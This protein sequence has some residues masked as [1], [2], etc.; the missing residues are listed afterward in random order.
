MKFIDI[1]LCALLGLAGYTIGEAI[2]SQTPSPS[3]STLMTVPVPGFVYR[4]EDSSIETLGFSTTTDDLGSG[5]SRGRATSFSRGMP[6]VTA[7]FTP[8]ATDDAGVGSV[9]PIAQMEKAT[10]VESA[11]SAGGTRL[12]I[13]SFNLI[14]GQY[15]CP[16]FVARMPGCSFDRV[17]GEYDCSVPTPAPSIS[18]TPL[19]LCKFDLKKGMYVCSE[20]AH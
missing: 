2:V 17:K 20:L 13:C 1:A 8:Q 5:D 16:K 9:R 6:P 12:P 15:D 4:R 18:K 11:F 7:E 3:P 14:K 19:P 10:S